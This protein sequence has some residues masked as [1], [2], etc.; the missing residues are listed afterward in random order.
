MNSVPSLVR[1]VVALSPDGS[2]I[3]Y[4]AIVTAVWETP[5]GPPNLNLQVVL[6]GPNANHYGFSSDDVA[7]GLCWKGTVAHGSGAG[8]WLY[9]NAQAPAPDEGHDGG[10]TLE[11]VTEVTNAALDA[12]VAAKAG[13]A[14]EELALDS[15]V[16]PPSTRAR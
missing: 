5:D 3:T 10:F 9:E 15:A 13:G 16:A 1:Y 14:A 6:D 4:P 11:D 12:Y 7:Q 8:M 2:P